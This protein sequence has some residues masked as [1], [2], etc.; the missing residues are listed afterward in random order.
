MARPAIAGVGVQW[1]GKEAVPLIHPAHPEL[2]IYQSE[3]ECGDG[4]NSWRLARHGWKLMH[5]YLSHGASAYL[6]WNI[7]LELGGRS[8]WG[9]A[10]NSLFT[11]NA[12]S[13]EYV[14]NHD[15]FVLKHVSHYVRPGARVIPT[16]SST[17][18]DNQLAFRN[19][20]GEVV[21]VMQNDMAEPMPV[22]VLIGDELLAATLLADSLNTFAVT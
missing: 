18:H 19:P 10:Q 3:Q 9:W 2:R 12:E 15:L 5:Y 8:S 14:A 17:G 13:G 22:P 6:Y 21:V 20:D 11:V 7:S 16:L 4:S 1:A